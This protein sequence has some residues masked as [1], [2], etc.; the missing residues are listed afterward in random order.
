MSMKFIFK[1]ND[2]WVYPWYFSEFVSTKTIGRIAGNHVVKKSVI[3]I[4]K[5]IFHMSYDEKSANDLGEY[6]F[7]KVQAD[8]KFTNQVVKNYTS[9]HSLDSKLAI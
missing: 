7:K 3:Y 6:F 4:E 2:M 1:R 5:D 8:E 9:P